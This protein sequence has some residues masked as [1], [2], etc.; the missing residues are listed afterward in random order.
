MAIDAGCRLA[1]RFASFVFLWCHNGWEDLMC[2]GLTLQLCAIS[3]RPSHSGRGRV[4]M[5]YY[6]DVGI[7]DTAHWHM[8]ATEGAV[9]PDVAGHLAYL[10]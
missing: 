5:L 9:S 8:N 10:L 3:A 6:E 1:R 7:Y 2:S 4:E